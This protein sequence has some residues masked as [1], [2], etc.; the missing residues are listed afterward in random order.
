MDIC[1]GI[2]SVDYSE[3]LSKI[4]MKLTNLKVTHVECNLICMLIIH[5]QNS[6]HCQNVECNDGE[7]DIVVV[8]DLY[9][10]YM[11]KSSGK[12]KVWLEYL[13]IIT[14]TT[15]TCDAAWRSSIHKRNEKMIKSR[16]NDELISDMSSWTKLYILSRSLT[17]LTSWMLWNLLMKTSWTLLSSWL[18]TLR[19]I[20]TKTCKA[21]M[22][23]W[24][25]GTISIPMFIM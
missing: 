3:K 1:K 5:P 8:T 13:T 14:E 10:M 18:R 19:F 6:Y 15:H 22:K 2:T 21:T 25:H 17:H 12:I 20:M 24:K 11:Q 23:A 9:H 7:L 4:K 16:N